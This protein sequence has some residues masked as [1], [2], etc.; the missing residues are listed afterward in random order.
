MSDHAAIYLREF[1]VSLNERDAAFM[2]DYRAQNIA[3]ACSW[4][5]RSRQAAYR[6][7]LAALLQGRGVRVAQRAARLA[8][9]GAK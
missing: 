8:R 9:W 3:S 1:G 7:A 2:L 6:L 4:D 5:Y